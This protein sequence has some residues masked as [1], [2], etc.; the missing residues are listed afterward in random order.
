MKTMLRKVCLPLVVFTVLFLGICIVNPIHQ[1]PTFEA[2]VSY[3]V[4]KE[5][6]RGFVL[7]DEPVVPTVTVTA[8]TT[9]SPGMTIFYN[10]LS[11]FA[12][13][14]GAALTALVMAVLT[15]LAK[16]FGIQLT[17]V[18]QDTVT[19]VMD[20]SV[21]KAEAWAAAHAAIPSSNDKLN[22][23]IQTARSLL[24]SDLAKKYTNEQLAHYA[25][26]SV[27]KAFNQTAPVASTSSTTSVTTETTVPTVAPALPIDAIVA[28]IQAE[29]SKVKPTV[30]T[31]VPTK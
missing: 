28:L 15:L 8:P 1:A 29:I 4:F 20:T 7:V 23:A 27:Y 9:Q 13:A 14:I 6:P 25:E 30:S 2:P 22:F 16:K 17:Q 24:S 12:V 21:H 26:E 3:E 5:G 19:G 10:I 18:E 11:T 31:T